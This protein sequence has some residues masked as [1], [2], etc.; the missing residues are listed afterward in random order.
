M[1]FVP[2]AGVKHGTI[3]VHVVIH[4]TRNQAGVHKGTQLANV[5]KKERDSHV[6]ILNM[7]KQTA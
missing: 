2:D 5:A 7:F 3:A 1:E 6:F 4:R